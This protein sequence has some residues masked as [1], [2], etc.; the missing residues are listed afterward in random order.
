M[1][2]IRQFIYFEAI[3]EVSALRND[4]A[5][6]S[7][8]HSSFYHFSILEVYLSIE[9]KNLYKLHKHEKYNLVQ[10]PDNETAKRPRGHQNQQPRPSSDNKIYKL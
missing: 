2:K 9:N 1:K 3:Y 5:S 10:S 8:R 7:G 6:V 4:N